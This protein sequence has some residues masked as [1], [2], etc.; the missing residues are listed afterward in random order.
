MPFERADSCSVTTLT[1]QDAICAKRQAGTRANYALLTLIALLATSALVGRLSYLVKPWDHDAR[2]FVYLGKLFCDGGWYCHDVIDNKFPTV[3]M[4]TS[5]AWRMFGTFWPGYVVLQLAMAV[6]GAMLLA[7][8]AA[9][10][11][12]E[13]AR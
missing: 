1:V 9:R 2:M 4:M 6:G 3:G 5:A 10:H 12:G 8:S 7:R 13:Q 11:F